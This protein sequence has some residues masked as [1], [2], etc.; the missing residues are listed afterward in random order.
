[1][2][3]KTLIFGTDNIY[4]KL[5]PFYDAQVKNGNLEIVA[6][7]ELTNDAVNLVYVD[8]KRGGVEDI[9][10]FDLVIISS[11]GDFY[12]RMKKLESHGLSRKKIIDGRVFMAPN[13]DFPRFLEEGVAHSILEVNTFESSS[14]TIYPK[15]YKYKTKDEDITLSL[16]TK[17]YI[18]KDSILEGKG[19]ITLGKF[20]SFAT[21]IFFSLGQN[22]SH[23]YS[24]VGTLPKSSLDWAFPKEIY[25]QR[26][27]CKI[28]IGNDVWAGR[29]SILKCTNPNKPLVIEDG[30]V[31]A[32]DSVVVKSVPPYAIVGGNPAQIIK[33]R[34]PPHVIK[35]LLRIKWWDW[36]LDK[37]HDNF[38]Y[39]NDVE[40]FISLHDPLKDDD[41]TEAE[42]FL[43]HDMLDTFDLNTDRI[44]N[45]FR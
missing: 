27:R 4:E 20:S 44:C 3:Y 40:K 39:F 36:S 26:K 19:L 28:N 25:P 17:S 21:N 37:I 12:S 31:I 8:G 35:A 10:N 13:L 14:R 38:K 32:S 41:T 11:N 29:G 1:M 23:N 45:N 42:N 2:A 9:P 22:R 33:Y 7:A 16:G 18:G 43:A 15:V 34:F 24:N 30:A 6:T 5:K